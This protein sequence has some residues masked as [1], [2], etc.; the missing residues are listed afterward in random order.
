MIFVYVPVPSMAL[1][2]KIAK[3]T[4]TSRL[5]ACANILP[6]MVSIYE[7]NNRLRTEN[8]TVLIL[9]A[10]PRDLKALQA[11]IKELHPYEVPCIVSFKSHSANA[12]FVDWVER[13][14]R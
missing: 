3:V 1:A 10:L 5:A 6:K 12:A 7:W 13:Q 4:V 11:K 9:K 8:E 14:T 2:K